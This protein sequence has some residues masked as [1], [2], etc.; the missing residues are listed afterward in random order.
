MDENEEIEE[1]FEED[2]EIYEE[3]VSKYFLATSTQHTIIALRTQTQSIQFKFSQG[4]L[5]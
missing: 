5:E 4:K 2:E 1:E 3:E